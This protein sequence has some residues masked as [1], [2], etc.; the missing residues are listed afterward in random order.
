MRLVALPRATMVQLSETR[1]KKT[2]EREPVRTIRNFPSTMSL[3]GAGLQRRVSIVP[4]SFSPAVMS[5]AG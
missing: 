3:R 4:R 2:A 1:E 5:I